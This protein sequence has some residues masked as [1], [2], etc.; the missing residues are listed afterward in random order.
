MKALH[1]GIGK[2]LSVLIGALGVI[3]IGFCVMNILALKAMEE[4]NAVIYEDAENM[5]EAITVDDHDDHDAIEEIEESL[6]AHIDKNAT[7]ISGTVVFDIA[8][9]CG[10]TFVLIIMFVI[11]YKMVVG[12]AGKASK[13]LSGIIN[14]IQ[15]GE[16]DLSTRISVNSKD[17]I[18]DLSR[19]INGF[20]EQLQGVMR[21]IKNASDVLTEA[22][23]K[24]SAGVDE[25]G[26]NA[27]NISSAMEE[28]AASMQEVSATLA[29]ISEGSASVLE[30]VNQINSEAGDGE[31]TVAAIKERAQTMHR[32]TASSK[33]N[34]TKIIHEIGEQ[35]EV[36]VEE[37]QGVNKINEL[38]GDILNIASQ[39]NLLALNASIEAARAGEAGK[40]FAVVADEIRVLA[41]NSTTTANDIQ[42]I[43]SLVIG[44]VGK[45]SS[46]AQAMLEF[47]DKD[48]I[49][50]Y[51][52]FMDIVNQYEADA[53]T[54]KSMLDSFADKASDM[55]KTMNNMNNGVQG[56]SASV[57]ESAK[58]VTSVAEDTSTLVASLTQIKE[59]SDN[60]QAIALEMHD[61]VNV[62]KVI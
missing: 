39:T 34:A 35:L 23:D 32:E 52:K 5:E 45:L 25:S 21:K 53:D 29:Q 7:K 61:E 12:P 13:E 28:L 37:S 17:E 18:G 2:K 58:A 44:A 1:S 60:N 8:V 48:V 3:M 42:H 36:A 43:S 22:S 4:N 59:V 15:N 49:T 54:M 27:M 11:L 10:F 62:F 9:G 6:K 41:E 55:S 24:I 51:D 26:Q 40:G 20:V 33:E 57:D 47:V 14:N 56:I 19:G 46:S 38:T 16:G 30:Q 31:V 50:D